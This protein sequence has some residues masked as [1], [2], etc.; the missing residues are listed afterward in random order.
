MSNASD[1]IVLSHLSKSYGEV[2]AVRS[3]DLDV[4][5]ATLRGLAG[6]VGVERRGAGVILTCDDAEAALRALL[7]RFPSV[8]DLEVR[9]AGL[10]DAFF[11]LT[12]HGTAANHELH[13][14]K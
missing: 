12:A 2:E 13:E 4:D 1:G 14:V 5:L 8:A 3:I 7:D 6:V 10:E 9:G 11:A